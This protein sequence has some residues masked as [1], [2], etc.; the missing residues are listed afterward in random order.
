MSIS[1]DVQ[2]LICKHISFLLLVDFT[3]LSSTVADD[4][5]SYELM[6][7]FLIVFD[8]ELVPVTTAKPELSFFFA[9]SLYSRPISFTLVETFSIPIYMRKYI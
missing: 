3:I 8:H 5:N 6:S 7:K 2:R 9:R 4:F 1:A